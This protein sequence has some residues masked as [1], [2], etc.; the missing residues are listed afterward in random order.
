MNLPL[1]IKYLGK[2]IP[3]SPRQKN[4]DDV[5]WNSLED[6]GNGKLVHE[7]ACWNSLEIVLKL[8]VYYKRKTRAMGIGKLFIVQIKKTANSSK[9]NFKIPNLRQKTDECNLKTVWEPQFSC[10]KFRVISLVVVLGNSVEI[11]GTCNCGTSWVCPMAQL[12]DPAAEHICSK[13]F[14]TSNITLFLQIILPFLL[15]LHRKFLFTKKNV[16]NQE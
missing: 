13:P 12:I 16:S 6:M 8:Y 11:A 2:P 7:K 14:L 9:E 5:N 10:R 1:G 3:S 4:C 15:K